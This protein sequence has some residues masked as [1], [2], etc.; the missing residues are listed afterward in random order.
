MLLDFVWNAFEKTGNINAY[1]FFKQIEQVNLNKELSVNT[2]Q[3][4]LAESASIK[5]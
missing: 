2:A 4:N 5:S 3:E 1:L